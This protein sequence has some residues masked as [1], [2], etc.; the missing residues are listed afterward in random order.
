MKKKFFI[1]LIFLTILI[2]FTFFKFQV[3][4]LTKVGEKLFLSFHQNAAA[5]WV[6]E[7][8][9]GRPQAALQDRAKIHFLLG[10]LYFVEN[11]LFESINNFNQAIKLNPNVKEYYYGRG[12][13]YGFSTPLFYP[14]AENDF[15]KYIEIENDEYFKNKVRAYGAWAGYN[16]LAW[17]FFL[18]GKYREMENISRVGLNIS[19]NNPW[20]NNMLGTSLLAQKKCSEAMQFLETADVELQKITT[21]NFGEAYSGDSPDFW[22]VGK[23]QMESTIKE[24]IELCKTFPQNKF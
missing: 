23:K 11:Q 5:I 24:N 13:S 17:I 14:D 20:L 1:Y 18:Q 22:E 16:D 9:L 6:L 7:S 2:G 3:E 10:R 12:L 19:H 15:R 8:A 21:K 4:I